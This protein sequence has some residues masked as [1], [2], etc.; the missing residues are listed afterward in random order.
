MSYDQKVKEE[1]IVSL[2]EKVNEPRTLCLIGTAIN[3]P[4]N[5]PITVRSLEQVISHF[6]TEGTLIDAYRKI[7]PLV[8]DI[9]V[10]MIKSSGSHASVSLRVNHEFIEEDAFQLVS[11]DANSIANDIQIE[12]DPDHLHILHPATLGGHRVS[13]RLSD[14]GVF[15]EL[16]Q[17]INN[18]A[19]A[20]RISVYAVC[21]YNEWVINCPFYPCNPSLISLQGGKDGHNPTIREYFL[22]LEETYEA[23]Q[24]VKI[25]VV[26]PIQAYIDDKRF[27]ESFYQ[28]LQTFCL[29]Q[30][31][32]GCFTH[33]VMGLNVIDGETEQDKV[34]RLRRV[35]QFAKRK[36]STFDD[37]SVIS[38]V[39]TDVYY[40]YLSFID[41]G[42]LAYGVL[43]SQLMP[44]QN[45]TNQVLHDSLQLKE[46]L[47]YGIESEF[48]ELGM[49]SFRYSPLK[50]S[51]VVSLD[52][53]F[54][55]GESGLKYY[56]NLRMCQDVCLMIKELV[57]EYIGSPMSEVTEGSYFQQELDYLMYQLG[58]RGVVQEYSFE[59]QTD[60]NS[61]TLYLDLSLKT[62]YMVSS[63]SIYGDLIYQSV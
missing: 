34:N 7:E 25:D 6:G 3:G 40:N 61:N 28:Q 32:Q 9:D 49:V 8:Y 2:V 44:N 12:L 11:V 10:T 39:A 30:V 48:S 5:T 57:D 1:W 55:D 14:Y 24:G 20:G 59:V 53:T 19:E 23:L 50:Q 31:E 43:L 27:G 22:S 13:Y 63:I 36:M 35:S 21:Y 4:V 38:V 33:G 45:A 52:I 16:A 26:V 54:T 47:S 62:K 37:C 46:R 41:S 58:S 29:A 17:A 51:P 18:D 56:H 42:Y 15:G 60:V